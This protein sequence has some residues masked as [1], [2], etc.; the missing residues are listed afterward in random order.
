MLRDEPAILIPT[1][2]KSVGLTFMLAL[3]S[4]FSHQIVLLSSEIISNDLHFGQYRSL[5]I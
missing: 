4:H 2:V 3:K 5:N 1:I